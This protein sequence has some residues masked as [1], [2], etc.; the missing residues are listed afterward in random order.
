MT[1]ECVCGLLLLHFTLPSPVKALKYLLKHQVMS[2]I[3]EWRWEVSSNAVQFETG[4]WRM[5]KYKKYKRNILRFEFTI[6][7]SWCVAGMTRVTPNKEKMFNK[8]KNNV[9]LY[10]TIRSTNKTESETS[11]TNTLSCEWLIW[12]IAAKVTSFWKYISSRA[13]CQVLKLE[14]ALSNMLVS[15]HHSPATMVYEN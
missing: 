15:F 5:K 13:R 8:E 7:N 1:I 9:L 12:L 4:F 11:K 3:A 10:Y 6:S 2:D 14:V